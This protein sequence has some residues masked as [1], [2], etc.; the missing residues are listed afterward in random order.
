MAD[1]Q[2]SSVLS[3]LS[4]FLTIDWFVNSC[5]YLFQELFSETPGDGSCIHSLRQVVI[6]NTVIIIKKQ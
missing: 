6:S 3:Y 4:H 5:Y 1:A 2:L